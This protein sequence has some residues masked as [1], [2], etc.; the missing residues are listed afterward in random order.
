MKANQQWKMRASSQDKATIRRVAKRFQ[1]TQSGTVKF[2]IRVADDLTR[3][4]MPVETKPQKE[5]RATA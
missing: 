2:L 3:E 1:L 5:Q 4:E